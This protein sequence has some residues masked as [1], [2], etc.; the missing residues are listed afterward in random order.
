M[1]WRQAARYIMMNRHLTSDLA[2]IGKFLPWKRARG[3]IPSMKNR[4]VNDKKEDILKEWCFWEVTPTETEMK[5][6]A[7]HV[8]E[9]WTRIIFENFSYRFGEKIY[10]QS[11]GGRIGTRVTTCA[12]RLVMQD[13]GEKYKASLTLA[14]MELCG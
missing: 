14:R 1:N 9:I 5:V 11:S 8:A 3:D 10:R 2:P 6:L 7:S 13:F 12:A 4:A